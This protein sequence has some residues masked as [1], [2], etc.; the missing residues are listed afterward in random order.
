MVNLEINWKD[1]Q[2]DLARQY[3]KIGPRN[4]E[5]ATYRALNHTTKRAR[6]RAST[7]IRSK[8]EGGLN[9]SK[10]AVDSRLKM[11]F[12]RR[13]R[14]QS[15]IRTSSKPLRVANF[16]HTVR[17]GRK[18]KAFGARPGSGMAVKVHK[19]RG[20]LIARAFVQKIRRK[21]KGGGQTNHVGIFARGRYTSSGFQ[22]SH[23]P[24]T[25]RGR[26]TQLRTTTIAQKL[27]DKENLA[28]LRDEMGDHFPTR[29]EH[30]LK[31]YAGLTP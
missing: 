28:I 5:T 16:P 31:R 11:S 6:T 19:G 9:A 26:L 13:G 21:T 12:A 3:E 15:H 27:D 29:L 17:K 22:F 24:G 20:K 1:A 25:G 7:Y 4:I 23:G 10:R 8:Q 2:R 14:L 30:H 18:A